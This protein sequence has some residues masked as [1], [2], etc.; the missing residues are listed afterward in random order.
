[1]TNA[2][3]LPLYSDRTRRFRE[4]EKDWRA[5]IFAEL[6]AQL[7]LRAHQG[8]LA[9]RRQVLA[10]AVDVEREHGERRAERIR[11][12]PPAAL[13]R[14]LQRCRDRLGIAPAQHALVEREGVAGLGHGLPPAPAAAA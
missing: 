7:V 14:S 9:R 11:L 13:G 2:I 8:A 3:P 6:F 12:A 5:S 1:M 10:R 4:S